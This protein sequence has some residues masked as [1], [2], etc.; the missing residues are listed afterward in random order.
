[1]KNI[2]IKILLLTTFL[3]LGTQSF[4]QMNGYGKNQ[5][6]QEMEHDSHTVDFTSLEKGILTQEEIDALIHMR[7]EE[8][9]ARDIY[10]VLGETTPSAVFKNIPRSEQTHMDAFDQLLDRYEIPDPVVDESSIGTFTDP[11]FTNLFIELKEKGQQ[12]DKDAFEV[13]AMV[14]DLNMANL[15]K[16]GQAT[17]K[18]DL[19]LAYDTLLKQSKNHM[20]AFIGQ[21]DRLGYEFEP[22]YITSEQLSIA[23]LEGKEHMD[24]EAKEDGG[25]ALEIQNEIQERKSIFARIRVFFTNLFR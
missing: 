1:M 2:T 25:H 11:F 19:K 20:S 10:T 18:P 5:Q 13:G 16:Y 23:V 12:S 6:K 22:E 4:A 17:D 15:I 24:Q 9:L 21:L 7:E 8:K 3:G 14:E